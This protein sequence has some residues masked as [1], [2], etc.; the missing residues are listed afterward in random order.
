MADVSAIFG[1]LLVLAIVFPGLMFTVWLLFPDKVAQ[2][3]VLLRVG[4]RERGVS[5]TARSS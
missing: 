4:R 1:I 3:E 2:E 5:S